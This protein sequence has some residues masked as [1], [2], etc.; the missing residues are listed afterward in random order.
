MAIISEVIGYMLDG[1]GFFHGLGDP[2]LMQVLRSVSH[3]AVEDLRP[4]LGS[5]CPTAS[6]PQQ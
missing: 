4:W 3:T 6:L 2:S 1:D 5:G